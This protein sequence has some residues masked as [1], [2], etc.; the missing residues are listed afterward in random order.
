MD[1]RRR[2]WLLLCET[3]DGITRYAIDSVASLEPMLGPEVAAAFRD[4]LI[5]FWR[6]WRPKQKSEKAEIPSHPVLWLLGLGVGCLC[7]G[8]V[9]GLCQRHDLGVFQL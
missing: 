8:G 3:V 6:L 5:K 4:R 1:A 9:G 2:L 7:G